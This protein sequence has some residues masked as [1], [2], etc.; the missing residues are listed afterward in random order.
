M[1]CRYCSLAE[2]RGR[3]GFVYVTVVVVVVIII[4]VILLYKDDDDDDD[5]NDIRLDLC[6]PRD[7]AYI[8]FLIDV[9]SHIPSSM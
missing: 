8:Y 2:R 9:A 6:G 1:F 7:T 4:I 5:D 3:S